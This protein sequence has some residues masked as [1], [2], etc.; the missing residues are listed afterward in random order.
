MSTV[1]YLET[2]HCNIHPPVLPGKIGVKSVWRRLIVIQLTQIVWLLE[3][4]G[5]T[6]G[7]ELGYDKSSRIP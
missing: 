1:F 5:I 2:L 3:V 7:V 6:E 4:G